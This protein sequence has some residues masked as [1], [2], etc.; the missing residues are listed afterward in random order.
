MYR[1]Y[2]QRSRREKNEKFILNAEVS[3]NTRS[4]LKELVGLYDTKIN[5]FIEALI[6][7]EYQRYKNDPAHYQPVVMRKRK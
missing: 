1:A 2:K 5:K 3:V 6:D 7:E 4:Q